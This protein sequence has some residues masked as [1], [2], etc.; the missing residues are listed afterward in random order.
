M[1]QYSGAFYHN[2]F[3]TAATRVA[4]VDAIKAEVEAAGWS[5]VSGSSGS[6][7]LESQA[8]AEGL[9]CR[10]QIADPG[11]GSTARI[12]CTNVSETVTLS[13]AQICLLPDA[14]QTWH[15]FANPYFACLLVLPWP[16][17][18]RKAGMFGTGFTPE[19]FH[20]GSALDCVASIFQHG[21]SQNDGGSAPTA[22]LFGPDPFQGCSQFGWIWNALGGAGTNTQNNSTPG[23]AVEF[24]TGASATPINRWAVDDSFSIHDAIIHWGTVNDDA[25]SIRKRLV[26]Y[27][28]MWMAGS[29]PAG[30]ERIW[31]GKIW[32]AVGHQKNGS[33]YF[34]KELVSP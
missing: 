16:N 18:T 20:A 11:S 17:V 28:A 33:F 7:K 19:F 15:I 12:H 32:V 13:G 3:T 27:D 10:V 29:V 22:T 34:L 30:T 2:T 31:D 23:P 24:L 25:T 5:V 9:Q 8:T 6:W 26:L 1:P 21:N 14:A 4:L